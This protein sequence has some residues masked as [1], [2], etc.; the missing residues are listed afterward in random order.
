MK[1]SDVSGQAGKPNYPE[2]TAYLMCAN[3][4]PF[5][6]WTGRSLELVARKECTASVFEVT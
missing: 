2:K 4:P 5:I 3:Q 6:Q 1:K